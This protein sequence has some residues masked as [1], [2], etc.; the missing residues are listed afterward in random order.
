MKTLC[1]IALVL[2]LGACASGVDPYQARTLDGLRPGTTKVNEVLNV[3]GRPTSVVRMADGRLEATWPPRTSVTNVNS[4]VV[5]AH[6]TES[7]VLID[8][9]GLPVS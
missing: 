7:G 8:I 5:R 9:V 3:L 6:F 1:A 2:I 4:D